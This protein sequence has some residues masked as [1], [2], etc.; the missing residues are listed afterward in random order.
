MN[1]KI[2]VV[3]GGGHIGLP[4]SVVIANS[5]FDVVCYDKNVSTINDCKKV[6]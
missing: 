1:K 2:T 4:L 5:G 6:R 3:G